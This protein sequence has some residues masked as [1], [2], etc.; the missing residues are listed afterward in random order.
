MGAS[1]R[2]EI[3]PEPE[4]YTPSLPAASPWSV[5]SAGFRG[6]NQGYFD[7]SGYHVTNLKRARSDNPAPNTPE[8][9]TRL[10]YRR[11]P[12][13]TETTDSAVVSE[14]PSESTDL[15]D[16]ENDASRLKGVR[17][18]GMGL[19][20]SADEAQK[21]M[22]NQ[23]KDDSVLRQMEETSSGIE[24]NEF[25]WTENG[26]FQRIRDI[27]ASPSIEGSPVRRPCW[28]SRHLAMLCSI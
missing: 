21:R 14:L 1:R 6:G 19:F 3:K 7:N 16:D 18:P 17:Y 12:S 26:E 15:M 25:V 5:D 28:H 24:P 13:E 4:E 22:R 8:N 10:K 2:N 9:G 11:W 27:Y 20:D 23:R